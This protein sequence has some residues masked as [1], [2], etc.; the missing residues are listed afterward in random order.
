MTK[1]IAAVVAI[2]Y[3]SATDTFKQFLE[4]DLA[5]IALINCGG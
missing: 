5:F 2:V 3:D 1:L 4:K